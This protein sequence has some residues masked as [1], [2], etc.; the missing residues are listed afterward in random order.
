MFRTH[1][2]HTCTSVYSQTLSTFQMQNFSISLD[3]RLLSLISLTQTVHALRA[4]G[5]VHCSP[6]HTTHA[7][8]A[9][10]FE[11]SNFGWCGHWQNVQY[12]NM[13]KPYNWNWKLFENVFHC[14]PSMILGQS[15]VVRVLQQ[16]RYNNYFV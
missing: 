1:E 10:I 13:H 3:I 2:F 12:C 5:C 16:M 8:D 15:S 4:G 14:L 7:Y 9:R 6:L 11:R